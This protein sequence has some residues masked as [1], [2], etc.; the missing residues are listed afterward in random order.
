MQG[1]LSNMNLS[2]TRVFVCLYLFAVTLS[3]Q[4][5]AGNGAISGSV[6]DSSGAVIAGA[7]VKLDNDKLGIHRDLKTTSGGVF[8]APALPPN[9]GYQLTITAPNF[10]EF[11]QTNVTVLVGQ[12]VSIPVV[13]SIKAGSTQIQVDD[14]APV[15]EDKI[16]FSQN[17]TQHQID[18]LPING[19][20]VDSFVL[21][22]PGVVPDGTFGLLSFRG[23]PGG[24]DFMTDGNDTTET[25][26]NENAGRTRLPTNISQDAVQEFQVLTD[27]YTAE[28][29]RA[30]GGVV[31]TITR[32]G[33]NQFHGSAFWFFRNRTLDARDPFATI[34]PA[35]ARHQF[36]GSLAG[37]LIKDK[38]FYFF[39]TEEQRRDFPLTSSIINPSPVNSNTQ[40]WNGCGVA[41]GGFPAATPAQCAAIN[42]TLPRF[43]TTL[44]RTADQDTALGKIDYRLNDKNSL[45][46]SLNY[47]HFYSPNGIQ[48]GAVVTSGGAL[49]S[50]G[51]DDVN[52]RF[53]RADW[54]FTPTPT[55][56]NEARFGW[57]KD[58][59]FDA[60]NPSL[61]DPTFGALT[62][63]V[64]NVGIG[65]GN[66][67]PRTQPSE[68]RYEAADN[69]SYSV[70]KHNLK[71]GV[72]YFNTEDYTNQLVNGNGS[73]TYSNANT[74]ALDYSGNATG[75]RDWATYSQ[76]FGNRA[77]DA[78]INELSLFAQDQFKIRPNVTLYYGIRYE[79]TFFPKP[80]LTNP[81]YPQ[82]GRIPNDSLNFAPRVG[83]AWSFNND[84][85]VVR[86]GY[87]LFYGRYPGAMV[88]SLFTTNNLYQQSFSLQGSNAAQLALGPVFPN[89]L[90]VPPS[91]GAGAATVGFAAPNLRTPYSQ[92]ANFAIQQAIDKNTSI[93]VSYLW[94]NAEQ[95][96]TVRDL[97]LAPP[98]HTLTYNIQ[99]AAGAAVGTYTTPVY[100]DSDR[101]NKNYARVL[102]VENGGKSDYNA[103]AVQIQRRLSHGLEGAVAYTWS[104]AIDTNLGAAGSNLFFGNNAP[105]TLFNGNYSADR[106]DGS[107]DQRQRLVI[108]WIYSPVFTSS[109]SIV[110]RFLIN[111]WQL[112]D[113]TT[114]GT[115]QPVTATVSV[116]NAL[117]TA[118]LRQLGFPSALAYTGGSGTLNGFGGS[119]RVPFLA[120]NTLRL[121][122]SYRTDV[123]LTK[124][125]PFSERY[126]TTLN[127]E[128]FN[129]TNTVTYTS[130][131]S[132]DYNLSG[133]NLQPANGFGLFTASSG[134]PDGTNARRA[135]ASIRIDF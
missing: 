41:G 31:N 70:G 21:L 130:L 90:P 101:I 9:S 6:S 117:T 4:T 75:A 16:A 68:N 126:R 103:L 107:L 114:I 78:K 62:L 8:S 115:G 15:N 64:N 98:T 30:L 60:V 108:N 66:Y 72:D 50:N 53:G 43:F 13:L 34:N 119:N 93:T 135:Q 55:L 74:F 47:Q 116:T 109:N 120:P 113:I 95:L 1:L 125:L 69:L 87:G 23:I 22:T 11:E 128:V 29:G 28:Y 124:I 79:T 80:P 110:A 26:Y 105:T 46:F 63:S 97:N 12:N 111:N 86:S 131:T 88:N 49:N 76:A 24:N 42:R 38:L 133:L 102:Q 17:V 83:F 32:S 118:Q 92:Q 73:Y 3:A 67:L 77:V 2:K 39:N 57:F 18:N 54:I 122:D 100:L 33:T 52:T 106:G 121:P 59:Q 123:R 94:S 45:S 132:R 7:Q 99:N 48:T 71:F 127:F 84:K 36:G 85:T 44:P 112:A 19:R 5:S 65:S 37:R 129:L 58:R 10:T 89:L 82:T 40:T 96:L 61:L 27:G 51:Y 81:D 35:E 25:F 56:V 14:L 91:A 104:H 134:F 20:R